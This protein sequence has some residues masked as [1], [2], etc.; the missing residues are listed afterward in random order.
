MKQSKRF[1]RVAAFLTVIAMLCASTASMQRADATVVE[2]DLDALQRE[3]QELQ[4]QREELAK[5]QEATKSKLD[6]LRADKSKQEEYKATLDNQIQTV[7]KQIDV[8]NQQVTAL[9][10]SIQGMSGQIAEKQKQV[11]VT[12]DELKKRLCAIYKTGEASSLQILLS[13]Q[14]VMDLANKSYLLRSITAHD[15]AL[16]ENLKAEMQGISSEKAEVEQDRADLSEAKIALDQKRTELGALQSEAQ[17]ALDGL[18]ESERAILAESGELS[19]EEQEIRKRQ[20]QAA[21]EIDQW[22]A[23]YYEEQRRKQE[24]LRRQQEELK[25]QQEE[26]ERRRQE[27]EQRRRE[28]EQNQGQSEL[29][30]VEEPE[31]QPEPTPPPVVDDTPLDYVGGQFTWPV[32]GYTHISCEYSSGHRAIDINRTD[33]KSI[34]GAPIV[35]ANGGKVVKAEWHYSYGNYVMI[36]HGGGYST[37]YAHASSLAVSAGQTVQKGQTIAYVGSTGD[38]S[39]PHLHFE[40]RVDGVRQN[41]FNWFSPA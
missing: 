7:Q 20:N 22:W 26:E 41:P 4:Q 39:G 23:N 29:P 9:N 36:D 30:P 21:A 14:N 11:D 37:L 28:E 34:D 15:T 13:S 19:M 6:S 5:Q 25:R 35:A 1:R 2:G 16:I 38:S 27:E 8:L 12:F 10:T 32:P 31:Q 33:G 24:E 3:Q 18:S 17:Q 40:V